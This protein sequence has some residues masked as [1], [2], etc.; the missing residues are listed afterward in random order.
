MKRINIL[1]L[2]FVLFLAQ[3]LFAQTKISG[4]IISDDSKEPVSNV[5]ISASIGEPVSSNA[6]GKFE[7]SIRSVRSSIELTFAIEDFLEVRSFDLNR[8][9]EVNLG[10]ILL[11]YSPNRGGDFIPTIILDVDDDDIGRDENISGI[12]SASRDLFSS[13][14][15]FVFGPARFRIRGFDSENNIAY[16][17]LIPMNDLEVGR[18]S[19]SS[20]GGLN[21]VLRNREASIGLAPVAYGLGGHAGASNTDL[22]ASFQRKQKKITYS[23]TN[24]SYTHRLIGAYSTGLM[25]NGWAVSLQASRRWA[26]EGYVPGTFYDAFS[27]FASVDKK[28]SEKHLLNVVVYGAPNK[29]GRNTA[30]IEELYKLAGTNYYNPY[31]GYQNGKKR[32]SR[33]SNLHTPT[34]MLRY[35]FTP[36]D[37][38]RIS[39]AASFQSGINGRTALDWY[40]GNDPR[41][42]YYRRLPSY[43]ED[44]VLSER[45]FDKLEDNEYE[46][47][48]KWDQLYESNRNSNATIMDVDGIPGNDVTGN[49]SNYIIEERRYDPT[50]INFNSVLRHNFSDDLVLNGG[51]QY[52]YQKNEN[53]REVKDLLGGEFYVDYDKFAEQDLQDNPD[54]IQN[55]LNRPNRILKEG[56]RFGH[57]FDANIRKYGAWVQLNQTTRKWD[58]SIGGE[59]SQSRFWR[60]GHMRNG[61]FPDNSFGD[62]EKFSFTNY[63]VKGGVTYKFSG[64][65]YLYARAMVG[66]RAP[67]FRNA[68][69]SPRTR[70]QAVN[71]LE[72]EN[73]RSGEVGVNFS[74]PYIKA[75]LVGFYGTFENQV[76]A[77]SFFHDDER[78]FVNFSMTGIDKRHMGIEASAEWTVTPGFAIQG[79]AS[80]GE[81]IYTS[82]PEATVTQDNNAAVLQD[83][84][85]VYAKNFYVSGTPQDAYSLGLSYRSKNYWALYLNAN[86]FSNVWID[87]NPVRRTANAVDLVQED[88][89][90]WR[91]I[92]DQEKARD[93]FTL[94]LSF[95]KSIPVYWFKERSFLAINLSMNNAFDNQDFVTG[96]YEQLRF[97]FE[98]KDVN[99]FPNRYFYFPGIS[100]FV[101][102]SL[103]F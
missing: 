72:N 45:V 29:R 43:F 60:T 9:E 90:M 101:N 55:D 85:T 36:S 41:P 5:V 52:R 7:L 14:A 15:A 91:G 20:F 102:L 83:G 34:A 1:T 44:P 3:S 35:D 89:D 16:L 93:A 54:A 31:W 22:R 49:L 75:R 82:R 18:I 50:I 51:I 56:D 76:L 77:R 74:A 58:I 13:T 78:S 100:Y 6:D 39:A 69:V 21:D 66:T 80:I 92:I 53:F 67:F 4:T 38:T 26:N 68:F 12:L 87:F 33:V 40:N 59:G 48:I 37:A 30:A 10:D 97:D 62:S 81:Y 47:Q 32:N 79:V 61:R 103:R 11:N 65:T 63:T 19:F 95:Y 57:D 17:N 70:N 96:G 99:R 25:D 98:G 42:D 8:K 24:R 2:F 64:R 86:Y 94:N 23:L 71:G 88:S 73:I 27:Y 84:L 46:L 28:F